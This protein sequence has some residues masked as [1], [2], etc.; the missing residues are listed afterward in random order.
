MTQQSNKSFLKKNLKPAALNELKSAFENCHNYIYANEGF[1]SEKIFNEI[2]KLIFIKMVDEN[3]ITPFSR[4]YITDEEFEFLKKGMQ[5]EFLE[6]IYELYEI[7]KLE[8][9]DIFKD[10][11]EKIDLKPLTLGFIVN[12]LQK[13]SLMNTST[14]V[15]GT[16]FQTF[17]YAHQR[18]DRGEFFTPYPIIKLILNIIQPSKEERIIDPACGSGGFLVETIKTIENFPDDHI[19]GVD[20]NSDL[21]KVAK[22]QLILNN[23][24]YKNIITS[25]S[26]LDLS[27]GEKNFDIL[28]TNPPFGS[29]G[30]INDK[31]ILKRFEL[32]HKWI[33][34]LENWVKTEN[35]LL[36]QAPE[37]LFIERCLQLLKAR[38]RMAI[39][40]PDGILENPT[41]GYIRKFIKNNSKLLAIINLPKE[42]FIPYG[43]GIGA[44]ILILQKL[45]PQILYEEIR[46]N[47]PI[48]F[49]NISKIGYEGTKYG[50]ITYKRNKKGEKIKDLK[51]NLVI[52]EDISEIINK[53]WDFKEGKSL[54]KSDTVFIRNYSEITDRFDPK[55]YQPSYK[56]LKDNLLEKGAIPLEK[57]VKIITE[58]ANILKN[59][60][61]EIKY[62]EISD[63]NPLTS[64]II[65]ASRMSVFEAPTRAS[66][67]LEK[68]DVIT[69]VAG[70]STGTNKHASAYIT[71]E[72]DGFI[73]TNGFRILRPKNEALKLDPYYL[74]YYLRSK[75]FLMQ[76]YQFRTGTTIPAVSEA[77]LKKILILIPEEKIQNELS[78]KVRKYY[79]LRKKSMNLING[80]GDHIID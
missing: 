67:K 74:L 41:Q 31:N 37:V 69:A 57:V 73:C 27:F 1:L 45:S 50:K 62:V 9:T 8:F 2:L 79:E 34:K 54:P 55:F 40:L 42:T 76:M 59:P 51:G 13:F 44:S 10:P 12:E 7:V 17:V 20:V 24:S 78:E 47:Y 72:F 70:V 53:Y 61:A 65:S 16:A 23:A 60:E 63:V 68:G 33:K 32:G 66:Y 4:F 48:F 43:T 15:K 26:L 30:K 21:I 46:R 52:D 39:V 49:A 28:M 36:K 75:E 19:Y 71:E 6:R 3:N 11:N 14:D 38:G 22:M 58:K 29:K 56:D 18:G 5:T 25:N 77:D 35:L 64:E 80:L